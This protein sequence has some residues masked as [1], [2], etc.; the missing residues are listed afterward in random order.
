MAPQEIHP[1]AL[2][3][4]ERSGLRGDDEP[5]RRGE[6]AGLEARF[7]RGQRALG[8]S[9]RID[10]ELGGALQERG[11]RGDA[12]ASLRTAGRAFE[13]GGDLLIGPRGGAG[14]VPGPPVRVGLGD[15]GI[16]QGTMHAVPVVRGCR[17]VG[18]G[19]DERVRELHA[20]AQLEQPAVLGRARRREVDPERPCGPVQQ[21]K[22]AEGLG[23]G[24][25]DE[26]L[27]VGREQL[28]APDVALLDPA[29][30]RLTA[31]KTEPAGEIG[32]VPRV[33]QLE[34]GERVAVALRDDLGA[35]GGVYGA[36]HAGQQ[37]RASIAVAQWMDRQD[38]QPG[39]NVIAGARPRGAHDHDPLGE[40]AAGHEPQDLRRGAVEPLRVVDDTGQRLLLGGLG[41]QRQRGQPHQEPVGRRAGAAA[42]HR[43]ERVALRSG[44][45]VQVVQHGR[46]ELVQAGVGQLHLRLHAGGSRDMPAGHPAGQ[47]AQQRALA[48]ARLAPQNG[49]PAPAR[50]RVGR[51]PVKLLALAVASEELRGRAG[52]LTRRP[53]PGIVQ[54]SSAA[55]ISRAYIRGQARGTPQTQGPPQGVSRVRCTRRSAKVIPDPTSA[56]RTGPAAT[57]RT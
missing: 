28:E 52:I 27:R 11:R 17:A 16:G 54:R 41:D 44:Q 1:G 15:G 26:Q 39:E 9:R 4:V 31:G 43:R 37:Q 5:E 14:P 29:G 47:I 18:G 10:R 53:P 50:E 45:P 19:P 51:E 34:Q 48:H 32:D 40:Q 38:R 12:A 56:T 22:V 36:G 20:P 23:G 49:G 2:E 55:G 8:S 33:R 30:D 6:R 3:F 35:D 21:D 13:L 24:R 25:E 46:A 42:E 57:P 7:R